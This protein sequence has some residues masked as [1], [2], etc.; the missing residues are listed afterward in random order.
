MKRVRLNSKKMTLRLLVFVCTAIMAVSFNACDKKDDL[1]QYEPGEIPGLGDVIGDIPGYQF[2]LPNGI[3]LIGEI[4]G[5]ITSNNYWNQSSSG[6]IIHY[7]GSGSGY[8]DLLLILR[9]VRSNPVTVTFPMATVF[10]SKTGSTQNGVLIQKVTI[11]IPANSD[12]NLGLVLFCGNRHKGSAGSGSV[13]ELGT[14]CNAS[15]LIDLCK[16]LQNKMIN[17]EKFSPTSTADKNTYNLQKALLQSI[18]W[19]VTDGNGLTQSDIDY[20][21]SLPNI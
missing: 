19:Q 18:V 6:Q 2:T 15:S 1:K 13:Y 14:V 7:Y 11:T 10:I 3:E 16:L 17:I 12:Y 20:I 8:V 4:T 9:N 5:A 21:N